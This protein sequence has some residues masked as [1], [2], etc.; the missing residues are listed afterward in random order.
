MN[1]LEA[2]TLESTWTV[3]GRGGCKETF[4]KDMGKEMQGMHMETASLQFQGLDKLRGCSFV[5]K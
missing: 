5:M 4:R 1:Q 3:L 2:V